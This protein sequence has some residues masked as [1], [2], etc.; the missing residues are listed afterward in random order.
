[1]DPLLV[2]FIIPV[3]NG[4]KH[5]AR[6]LT[7]ILNQNF[8][9]GKY[10]IIVVDNGS[11]DRT[12]QI[13]RNLGVFVH[14]V[15]G[16][17]V[18]ALRNTGARIAR[19]N[20]LAFVDSDVEIAP[21]WL[22]KGLLCFHDKSVISS[23]CFPRPPSP[24]TWVQEAW[25]IH[26]C[27]TQNYASDRGVT[28][29][30]SMNL[31]VRR[32]AFDA[33]GG[34]NNVMVT[35]E[36]VDLCY[37]LNGQGRIVRNPDMEA[38]HWGEAPDLKTFWRKEVWRGMGTLNGIISHGLHV[39]ELPSVGYPIYV[40]FVLFFVLISCVLAFQNRTFE[41]LGA[42]IFILITPAIALAMRTG[43]KTE[44]LKVIPQLF[45]LY[46]V[47]GIARAHSITKGFRRSLAASVASHRRI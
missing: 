31:I 39:T 24:S 3:L 4:E 7:S 2:S 41:L 32:T 43:A 18:G 1:M 29:L 38:I 25:G 45:V 47:Y 21:H 44:Q 33:I 20:Y 19:G 40:T 30:P 16:V 13:V 35:A 36:D 9:G 27:G 15:P 17:T 42:S 6:C 34:F 10:E 26:Q 23:G 14:V 11:T 5:I 37:R 12:Q 28:W 8:Q 22:E 46:L